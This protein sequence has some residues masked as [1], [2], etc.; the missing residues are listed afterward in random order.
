MNALLAGAVVFVITLGAGLLG[1]GVK[2]R[3]TED[4]KTGESRGVV[5]QIAGLVTLL[6]AL[7][8]G[9]LI[10]VSYSYFATQKTEL[11]GFSSQLLRLDQ[12][13]KQYGPETQPVREKLKAGAVKG[14]EAFWGGGEPDPEAL[15]VA[16]PLATAQATAD[17]LATLQPKTDGQKAALATANTY[18]SMIEQ[19]R[20]LMALQIASPPV[21]WILIAILIFWTAALF[22]GVG[23]YAESNAVVLAA[24]TFGALSVAFAVFLILGMGEP[25]TGVVKV[26]PAA[27]KE[28]IEFIGK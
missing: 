21:S 23:L 7:V 17:F 15:T 6:L 8:L 11:E 26:N 24:L 10:G 22:F 20:L 5:G 19:S 27:L 14:Y 1:L 28:A 13:L 25:F 2:S 4:H 3:L 18:A 16:G 9:T 12:A